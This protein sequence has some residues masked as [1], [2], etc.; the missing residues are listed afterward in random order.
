MSFLGYSLLNCMTSYRFWINKLKKESLSS[1]GSDDKLHYDTE[2]AKI[3]S[4]KTG[5][6]NPLI[7]G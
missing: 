2:Q 1:P 5:K 6:I 3:T 7:F 4:L